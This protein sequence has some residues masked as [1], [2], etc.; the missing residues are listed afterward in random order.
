MTDMNRRSIEAFDAS[1]RETLDRMV[2][3]AAFVAPIVA[4]FAMD[5]LKISRAHAQVA[6]GSGITT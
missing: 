5:S 6:N 1:K 3:G 2:K 4:S